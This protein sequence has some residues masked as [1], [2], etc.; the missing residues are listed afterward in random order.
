[1]SLGDPHNSQPSGGGM[2]CRLAYSLMATHTSAFL[3][4]NC[5]DLP[6]KWVLA[7]ICTH[8]QNSAENVRTWSKFVTVWP[9]PWIRVDASTKNH[10]GACAL[11]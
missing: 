6:R 9:P 1:M 3:V 5:T 10:T 7:I 2:G 4:E 8:P 11:M